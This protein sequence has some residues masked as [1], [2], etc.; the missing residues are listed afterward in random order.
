VAYRFYLEGA[1]H[2]D[3]GEYSESIPFLEKAVSVDPE[4]AMAYMLMAQNH[5]LLRNMERFRESM[6][7][8]LEL[9]DRVS[10]REHLYIQAQHEG[11]LGYGQA[12]AI[13][14]YRRLLELYPDD[15]TALNGLGSIYLVVEEL[16]KAE[17]CFD[18]ALM[19]NPTRVF[20]YINL[21]NTYWNQGRI[22]D[23]LDIL[24]TYLTGVSENH[25]IRGRLA[26]T[27][28]AKGLFDRALEEIDLAFLV[29]PTVPATFARK[30]QI[31]M[32]KEDFPA[33][34][35]ELLKLYTED[36]ERLHRD[37]SGRLTFLY[38]AQGRYQEALRNSEGSSHWVP[39]YIH[40]R[41]GDYEAALNACEA[42][43][44]Q[45]RSVPIALIPRTFLLHM[46]G[47]TLGRM[48]LLEEAEAAADELQH[49]IDGSVFKR[50]IRF[51]HHIDGEAKHRAGNTAQALEDFQTAIDL[52]RRVTNDAMRSDVWF[53]YSLANALYDSGQLEKARTEFQTITEETLTRV[54]CGD[55]FA[56]AF[57]MLGRI[58][59]QYGDTA[60]AIENY[61][62]FLTLWE[63]ADPGLAEVEA[64]QS[65]LRALNGN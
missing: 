36:R 57:Y 48:G 63:D 23:A 17:E 32:F 33:A 29:N 28:A 31:L 47:L 51:K 44:S 27:Y 12:A 55:I 3:R 34:E 50:F 18:K 6:D 21:Q 65:R 49:L 64:A 62:R 4:F 7:K 46:K 15:Y 38:I 5:S 16:D 25:I 30:C 35:Q 1:R 60:L 8:A 45:D 37:A 39:T 41:Q 19:I 2:Q 20:P 13:D 54:W 52:S 42:V 10:V 59:E 24:N 61:R 40:L 43:L 58:F 22:D 11:Y 9:T 56:Q 53:R 26:M 14:T